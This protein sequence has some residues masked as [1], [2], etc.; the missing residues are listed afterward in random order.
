MDQIS[1]YL[2][3]FRLRLSSRHMLHLARLHTFLKA[4]MAFVIKWRSQQKL[5]NEQYAVVMTVG[6][7]MQALGQNIDA[8]NLLEIYEYLRSSKVMLVCLISFSPSLT[9]Y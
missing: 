9:S 7:V 6:E 1:T 5:S 2:S 3:K 8:V 4:F